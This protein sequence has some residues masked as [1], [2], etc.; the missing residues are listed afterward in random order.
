MDVHDWS[1]LQN[2]FS[3]ISYIGGVGQSSLGYGAFVFIVVNVSIPGGT[4]QQSKAG[5][6][7]SQSRSK[8]GGKWPQASPRRMERGN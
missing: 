1:K 2:K 8:V 7:M 4:V 6:Y 3:V 5:Y